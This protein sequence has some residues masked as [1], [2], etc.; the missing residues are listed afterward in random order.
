MGKITIKEYVA[1]PGSPYSHKDARVIGPVLQALA[2]TGGVTTR[3]VVD[4]A[5][6]ENSPLHVYFE[7]DDKIAADKYRLDRARNM[8]SAIKVR[9]IE[10]DQPKEARA[11]QV[12]RT[13][14][15]E[16]SPRQYRSFQVLH[17]DSAF[18]AQMMENAVDDLVS[19][20]RRYEPYTD[21][22]LKFGDMFEVII[23]QVGEFEQ[24]VVA[25]GI[26]TETDD[27]LARL[28]AWKTDFAEKMAAWVNARE[29]ITYIMEAIGDAE[30]AFCKVKSA[31][32]KR[33]VSCGKD[34]VTLDE[35]LRTCPE[36]QKKLTY[37]TAGQ[38]ML[39][40]PTLAAQLSG[41]A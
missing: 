12:T 27:A 21:M 31:A 34:F 39:P 2:E 5:R 1:D 10:N 22:W 20:R 18:A 19:W 24:E 4:A 17:G 40:E 36:C 15:Y 41:D 7:W 11:F 28:L 37:K 38:R 32:M 33:C 35:G 25:Q 16:D 3:D 26:S 9:Y 6:S 23:N 30:A 14:A 13:Q 29:Q 8:L